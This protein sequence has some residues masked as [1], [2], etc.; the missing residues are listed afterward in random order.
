[1]QW[2][3][4]YLGSSNKKQLPKA[5]ATSPTVWKICR[6]GFSTVVCMYSCSYFIAWHPSGAVVCYE[7][8]NFFDKL[9]SKSLKVLEGFY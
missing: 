6:K 4:E 1:M 8:I 3:I 9:V 2:G 7:L 5:R